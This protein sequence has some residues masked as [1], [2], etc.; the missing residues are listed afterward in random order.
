[1]KKLTTLALAALLS[2]VTATSVFAASPAS[3]QNTTV[4]YTAGGSNPGGGGNYAVVIPS[5]VV[6]KD[7]KT[8]SKL[9][10]E[11]KSTTT[12]QELPTGLQVSISVASGKQW[13][14]TNDTVT[15]ANIAWTYKYKL[16]ADST[17]PSDGAG[18]TSAADT[19]T[20][21]T[22]T[23]ATRFIVGQASINA[24]PNVNVPAGTT[25]QDTLTY[26]IQETASGV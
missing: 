21:G 26:T 13:K 23:P 3:T 14:L 16:Q 22:L 20:L 9:D 24:K 8:P 18:T 1:M 2:T 11:L 7:E 15:N 12:D 19:P 5:N 25:F 4:G 10:V 6:I 17:Y